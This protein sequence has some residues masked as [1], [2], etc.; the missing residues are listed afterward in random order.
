MENKIKVKF[1]GIK[2][3]ATHLSSIIKYEFI[4]K[5]D[6]HLVTH[7]IV[8]NLLPTQLWMSR[9]AFAFFVD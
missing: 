9:F 7:N 8:N 5:D 2:F 3:E 6:F 1:L 4:N